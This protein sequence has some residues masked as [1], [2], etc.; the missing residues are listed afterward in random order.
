M[1][2]YRIPSRANPTSY[3][4]L[5]VTRTS[6][7]CLRH[8]HLRYRCLFACVQT[9]YQHAFIYLRQLA[10]HLRTALTTQSKEAAANVLSWSFVNCLRLWSSVLV[11]HGSDTSRPL[12]QLL[13]PLVQVINGVLR[14][15]PSPRYY[16]MRL[17]LVSCLNDMAWASGVYIPTSPLLIDVL[18]SPSLST[19]PKG[20]APANPPLLSL[21]V[22]V[23]KTTLATRSYQ[24]ALASRTFELLLDSLKVNYCSVAFPELIVPVAGALRSFAKETR[25]GAWRSRAKALL[26]AINGQAAKIAQKRATLNAA[27]GDRASI[28]AFMQAEGAALRAERSK[29]REAAAK[30]LVQ[31][32][33]DAA[34]AAANA[35][36]NAEAASKKGSKQRQQKKRN[37]KDS[38]DDS[39]NESDDEEEDEEE[40][41][42][43]G[44]GAEDDEDEDGSEEEA[45]EEEEE[46]PA[47][48]AAAAAP[49]G[50]KKLAAAAAAAAASMSTKAS[51]KGGKKA[52]LPVVAGDDVVEDFDLSDLE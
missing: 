32:A 50:T 27:P 46:R 19:K 6:S 35:A 51:A 26:D 10:I 48:R 12:F 38:D 45:E 2:A 43:D 31:Q 39:D 18:R 33:Q 20:A 14:M 25:V 37:A 40:S 16:P 7:S 41:D 24:D 44:S 30:E 22:K 29:G 47:K 4:S 42:F 9:S 13:Y 5:T 23:G 52:M 8:H 15:Q 28:A 3:C 34:V 36:A 17:H 21:M 49:A 11:R 1:A